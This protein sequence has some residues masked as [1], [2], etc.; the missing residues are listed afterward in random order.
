M[1]D[2]PGQKELVNRS[3][4]KD[5]RFWRVVQQAGGVGTRP[6]R[7]RTCYAIAT[8]RRDGS[9]HRFGLYSEKHITITHDVVC[10]HVLETRGTTFASAYRKAKAAMYRAR[11]TWAWCW[12]GRFSEQARKVMIDQAD[13]GTLFPPEDIQAK[14]KALYEERDRQMAFVRELLNR[15]DATVLVMPVGAKWT[16]LA[17]K[18]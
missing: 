13:R 7:P 5:H 16:S 1:R 4:I 17:I 15:P 10:V 6:Y 11:T 3:K 2:P 9:L 18:V 8:V 12:V 14:A